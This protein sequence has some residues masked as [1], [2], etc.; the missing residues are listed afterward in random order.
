MV[1]GVIAALMLAAA[2]PDGDQSATIGAR[3]RQ[4]AAA[5]EALQGPL[6][7]GWTLYDNRHRALM[8]FELTDPAGGEGP[9]EGA[10][11]ELGGGD[12][13]GPLDAATRQG[14]RVS[15]LFRTSRATAPTTLRLT[16][17]GPRRWS[18]WLSE[19]GHTWTVTL[20]PTPPEP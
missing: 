16:R 11:R 9:P 1:L 20:R 5:A 8:A 17:R 3:L 10:W 7:G 4:S 18:G 19:G 14:D 12:G 13:A 6:D 15:M 2:A